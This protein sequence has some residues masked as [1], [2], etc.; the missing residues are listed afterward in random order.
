MILEFYFRGPV[1]VGM[2]WHQTQWGALELG[3]LWTISFIVSGL[4]K[5]FNIVLSFSISILTVCLQ[6][7]RNPSTVS[8]DK[9][10]ILVV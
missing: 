2:A 1:A 6:L 5:L 10:L 7:S 3:T 9:E 4:Q 8:H